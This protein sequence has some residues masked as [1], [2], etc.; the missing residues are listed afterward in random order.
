MHADSDAH[1]DNLSKGSKSEYARTHY[2][3]NKR[4]LKL[5]YL[6]LKYDTMHGRTA[7]AKDF[8]QQLANVGFEAEFLSNWIDHL[9][10]CV[11]LMEA[12]RNI[13]MIIFISFIMFR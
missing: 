6:Q 11:L 8:C 12:L 4:P 7:I 5:C 3:C 2:G 1:Y 9:D 13:S 10:D